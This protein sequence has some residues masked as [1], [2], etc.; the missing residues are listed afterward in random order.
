MTLQEVCEKYK[1]SESSL[2][3]MFPRT[4]QSILKKHGVKIIKEGRGKNAVYREEIQDDKRAITMYN[5]DKKELILD[6]NSLQLM[7]WDFFVLL[8]IVATPMLVFRGSYEDFLK[9][10]DIKVSDNNL[11]MLKDALEG[12]AKKEYISYNI[13]KTNNN[14][15]VA[16]IYRKVEEEMSIGINMVKTCKLLAE[17]YHK[18]SWVPLLKTWLGVEMLAENQPYTVDTL[19]AITGLS[20]Y[21]VRESNKILKEAAIY[22]TSKAY[23]NYCTCLGTNVD[24]NV[25]A[26]YNI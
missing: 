11:R 21:Q 19:C 15:F 16:S 5:E 25:E 22:Q 23:L 17:K 18:R 4:Q 7:N 8:S 2:R 6:N 14:Y 24:L 10:T 9:Y 1:V 26:F 13:D 20:A 3:K 12:L